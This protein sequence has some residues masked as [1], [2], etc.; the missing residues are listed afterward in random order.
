MLHISGHIPH[1]NANLNPRNPKDLGICRMLECLWAFGHLPNQTGA[2]HAR[3]SSEELEWSLL[4]PPYYFLRFN[5][6]RYARP[7]ADMLNALQKL[8]RS[9]KVEVTSAHLKDAQSN[10]RIDCLLR[11]LH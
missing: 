8:L 1:L 11:P 3:L 6:L 5:S 4:Q 7:V 9:D 2:S 10:S